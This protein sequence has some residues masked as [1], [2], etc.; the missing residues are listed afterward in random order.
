MTPG[1]TSNLLPFLSH[2]LFLNSHICKVCTRT[3]SSSQRKK[4]FNQC[5]FNAYLSEIFK[6]HDTKRNVSFEYLY[7]FCRKY[8]LYVFFLMIS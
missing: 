3:A 2:H 1:D 8:Y 7:F 6:E 4:R 5:F